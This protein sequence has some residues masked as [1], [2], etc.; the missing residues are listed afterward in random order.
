[1]PEQS[2]HDLQVHTCGEH[3]RRV[4]VAKGV[5][6]NVRKGSVGDELLELPFCVI[7]VD[8]VAFGGGKDDFRMREV[9]ETACV[10]DPELLSLLLLKQESF[11][12]F[13]HVDLPYAVLRL[14]RVQPVLTLHVREVPAYVDEVLLKVHI[15]PAQTECL[16][17]PHAG[18][19]QESND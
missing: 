14:R 5:Q 6:G 9:F 13:T 1:M 12:L 19:Q 11:H 16:A 4:R 10:F 18:Q 3:Q 17:G 7:V 2:G 15:L 8:E